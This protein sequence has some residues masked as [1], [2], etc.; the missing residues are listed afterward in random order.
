M[1]DSS[2]KKITIKNKDLRSECNKC[3]Y[4]GYVF[5]QKSTLTRH[6]NKKYCKRLKNSPQMVNKDEDRQDSPIEE[7]L[8]IRMKKLE[9]QINNRPV[10]QLQL[11]RLEKQMEQLKENTETVIKELKE[12]PLMTQNIL[13]VVCINQNDNYLD[14]LTQEWGNFDKALEY[15]KDCALSNITGDCKLVEKIYLDPLKT[16]PSFHYIDKSRTRVEYFNEKQERII[17]NKIQLGKKL[18]NNLQ[19][20]YLKGV[21]YLINKNLENNKCPNKFLEDYDLQTW[22][23]HIYNLSDGQ[24]QRK[25][26]G[27]LKIPNIAMTQL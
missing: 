6:L 15:I 3:P 2:S 24:Y 11:D 23:Q 21:N 14:M 4:C 8:E 9:E 10:T 18:A 13:Q 20:S 27:Q 17:D 19:N 1:C 7:N 5:A 16:Q 12:K 25:F 26:I 22:N